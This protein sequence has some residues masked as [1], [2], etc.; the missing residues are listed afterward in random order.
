MK[1]LGKEDKLISNTNENGAC[2]LLKPSFWVNAIPPASQEQEEPW[3][4]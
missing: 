4:T 1:I 3:V 2:A